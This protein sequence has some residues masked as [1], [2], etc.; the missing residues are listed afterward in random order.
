LGVP[1]DPDASLH[2]RGKLGAGE[3]KGVDFVSQVDGIEQS[4]PG[5]EIQ[6]QPSQFIL[7]T[8]ELIEET[9]PLGIGL[10]ETQDQELHFRPFEVLR[11]IGTG[12]LHLYPDLFSGND[13]LRLTQAIKDSFTDVSNE[14]LKLNVSATG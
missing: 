2:I 11:E 4:P 5:N 9:W 10:L 7:N 13:P 8:E 6:V 1:A 12:T 14:A 3:A